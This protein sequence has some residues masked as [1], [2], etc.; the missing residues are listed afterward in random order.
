MLSKRDY[1]ATLRALPELKEIKEKL[2]G[3]YHQHGTSANYSR[4]LNTLYCQV[5][6]AVIQ[7]EGKAA[8]YASN[9]AQQ[10]SL[11]ETISPGAAG[12]P[13]VFI[14]T[15]D[16]FEARKFAVLNPLTRMYEIV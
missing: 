15:R 1:C 8:E 2:S 14:G 10:A 13:P 7:L 4:V 16:L 6:A 11:F 9:E 5:F 3:L 12:I